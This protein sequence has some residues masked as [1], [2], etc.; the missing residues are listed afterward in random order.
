[1]FDIL[2]NITNQKPTE[3]KVWIKKESVKAMQENVEIRPLQVI[4]EKVTPVPSKESAA[5]KF[6]EITVEENQK[7]IM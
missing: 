2:K 1:M 7:F 6:S 4:Q 3:E 5:V